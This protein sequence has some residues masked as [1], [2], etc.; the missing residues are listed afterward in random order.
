MR[1]GH[2]LMIDLLPGTNINALNEREKLL[3]KKSK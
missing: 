2:R 3:P 1:D